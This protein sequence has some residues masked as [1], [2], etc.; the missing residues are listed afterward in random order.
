[1]RVLI[2]SG[3]GAKGAF[4]VGV[5]RHLKDDR[6]ISNFDLISGT[7]TGAL[8]AS[9]ASLGDIDTLAN[10][11]LNTTNAD[12]L[13]PQ[14]IVDAILGGNPFVYDTEPLFKQIQQNIDPV[15]YQSIMNSNCV[16]CFNAVSLQSGRVTVFATKNII[17][18]SYYDTKI[19]NSREMFI[20][21]LLAS[22]NQAVFMNP[23][24]IGNDDYVDGGNREVVPTRVVVQNLDIDEEHEIY[25]ISNNPNDLLQFPGKQ[26]TSILDVLIRAINMFVQEVRE[27]DLEVMAKYKTFYDLNK[28]NPAFKMKIFYFC[29]E[30]DLDPEF[31][32]GLRFERGRMLQ[33]M[34]TGRRIADEILQ[35]TPSGNFP[36]FHP[37]NR[38]F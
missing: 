2:T 14:N 12:I 24:N 26:F 15:T 34:A 33:W 38:P 3:G 30:F 11:Y 37:I 32:T 9:L 10:I 28:T 25:V 36:M 21:A 35:T 16:L 18:A 17:P 6:G 13:K 7:S 27:N 19:I 8:I 31:S 5:L 23:I 4:S 1:M 20:D 29:P 22:S